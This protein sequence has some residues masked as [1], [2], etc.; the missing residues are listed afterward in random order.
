[1]KPCPECEK[2]PTLRAAWDQCFQHDLQAD[3]NY[4]ST[5][6]EIG[7]EIGLQLAH[8]AF[9]RGVDFAATTQL[10]LPDL[11]TLDRIVEGD[12]DPSV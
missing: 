12:L 1:M 9:H 2:N 4:M 6:E 8:M 7:Y 3:I 11:S 10:F 5:V